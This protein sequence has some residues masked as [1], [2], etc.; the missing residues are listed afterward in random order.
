VPRVFTG[1]KLGIEIGETSLTNYMVRSRR[2][3]CGTHSCLASLK[4]Y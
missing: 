4:N 3:P 2:P 1:R